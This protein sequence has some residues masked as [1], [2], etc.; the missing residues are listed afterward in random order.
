MGAHCRVDNWCSLVERKGSSRRRLDRQEFGRRVKGRKEA[1]VPMGD[2]LPKEVQAQ[3]ERPK[4]RTGPKSRPR[5]MESP[6]TLSRK[7]GHGPLCRT[8]AGPS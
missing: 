4:H 6:G 5:C 8:R 3:E 2:Q 1:E 7:P